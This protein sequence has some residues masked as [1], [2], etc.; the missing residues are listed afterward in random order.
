MD[1]LK[2]NLSFADRTFSIF[3]INME[4]SISGRAENFNGRL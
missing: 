3:L 4:N 2:T 1:T